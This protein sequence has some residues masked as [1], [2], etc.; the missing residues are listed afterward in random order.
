MKKHSGIKIKTLSVLVT[1]GLLL[2]AM[3]VIF[4][5][6]IILNEVR[7]AGGTWDN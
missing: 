7:K 4:S 6:N 2:S 5:A 3:L 1:S